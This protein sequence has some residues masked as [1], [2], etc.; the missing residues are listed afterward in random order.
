[1]IGG[2]FAKGTID[3]EDLDEEEFEGEAYAI[4]TAKWNGQLIGM[5]HAGSGTGSLN[6]AKE[7]QKKTSSSNKSSN[8]SNKS[9]NNVFIP[10]PFLAETNL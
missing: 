1:M 8:K 2:S 10:S 3:D 4:G 5:S 9:S 6:S 7:A